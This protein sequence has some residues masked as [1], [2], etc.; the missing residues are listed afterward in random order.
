[1]RERRLTPG[2]AVV[3]LIT[4]CSYA[5][6]SYSVATPSPQ[7]DTYSCTM[8]QVNALG[9]T[10]ANADRDAGLIVASKQTSGLGTAIFTGKEYHDQLSVVVFEADANRTSI[11][12]TAA[13]STQNAINFGAASNSNAKPS[14]KVKQDAQTL[15]QACAP[16]GQITEEKGIEQ[17]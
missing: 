4:A 17:I 2:I 14:D 5:P 16:D 13:T 10:V 9:Y 12:V 7:A 1:M 8:R 11:R 15:L 3:L 6:Q